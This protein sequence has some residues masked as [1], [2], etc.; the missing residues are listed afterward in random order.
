MRENK[1]Y[2]EEGYEFLLHTQGRVE[3][4]NFH[5]HPPKYIIFFIFKKLHKK[6]GFAPWVIK[7]RFAKYHVRTTITSLRQGFIFLITIH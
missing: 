6:E 3:P 2:I 7:V 5:F 1:K 4:F